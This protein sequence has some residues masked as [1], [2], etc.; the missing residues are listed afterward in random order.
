MN[1]PIGFIDKNSL[2]FVCLLNKSIYG[3]KQSPRQWNKK[4]N[5]CMLALGFTRSKY[6]TCM[7]MKVGKSDCHIF[8]LLYVDDLLL[9]GHSITAIADVKRELKKH[10]DM[11][12]FGKAQKILG[13]KIIRNRYDRKICLSQVDYVAK[14]LD[15]F[16][17]TDAKPSPVPLGGHLDISKDDCPIIDFEKQKM[18]DVPYDVDVGSLK[19]AMLCTRPD[20][21]FAVIVLSRYM[22]NPGEKHWIAMK[23]LLKYMNGTNKLGLVYVDYEREPELKGYVDSNFA[24]NRDN[25]KSVTSFFFTWGGCCISW[26]SQQQSIVALSSTEAEYIAAI[27]ACKEAI[28]SQGFLKE[29]TSKCYVTTL[30]IDNQSTLYLCKDPVYHERTKHIDVRLH[31][32]RDLVDSKTVIIKKILGDINPADFG[33]KIVPSVKFVFCRDACTYLRL[34]EIKA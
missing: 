8:V 5:S 34:D 27:E 2:D 28:W 26:K 19:Y 32:I 15:K 17:M 14:V 24:S 31:F 9:M 7:Y 25:R 13:V 23:Y 18:E 29:I 30:N 11:K 6:D 33:T 10:F 22:S 4:F 12:D 20:I 3:L 1:Q 16:A 21:A